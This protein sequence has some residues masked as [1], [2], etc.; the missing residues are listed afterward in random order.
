M[1]RMLQVNAQEPEAGLTGPAWSCFG[2]DF[3]RIPIHPSVAGAIQTKLE[4][5]KPEDEYEQ[6]ADRIADQVTA[7]PAHSA[8]SGLPPRVQRFSRQRNWQM[9]AAPASVDHA[10]AGPGRP[11]DPAFLRSSIV[12]R[13]ATEGSA[14]QKTKLAPFVARLQAADNGVP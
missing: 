14:S 5:N 11:L 9:D 1:Q 2:Q 6:E 10:L 4:V 12:N 13:I 7:T 3:R 8:A